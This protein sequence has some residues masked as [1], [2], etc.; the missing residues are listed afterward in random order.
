MQTRRARRVRPLEI[1][2]PFAVFFTGL[3]MLLSSYYIG[4]PLSIPLRITGSILVF[5]GAFAIVM[6]LARMIFSAAIHR[7]FRSPIEVHK[8]WRDLAELR[9]WQRELRRFSERFWDEERRGQ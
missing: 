5:A 3:G 2:V 7:E 1:I 8:H 4:A 9:A 6:P